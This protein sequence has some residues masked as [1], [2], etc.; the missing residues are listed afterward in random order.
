MSDVLITGFIRLKVVNCSSVPS[1]GHRP[2]L[3]WACIRLNRLRS[4]YRFIGLKDMKGN[5]VRGGKILVKI[6]K[7]FR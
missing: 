2:V 4:G 5:P 6:E 7:Q 1:A 3:A